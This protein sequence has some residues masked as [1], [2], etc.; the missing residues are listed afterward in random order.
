M[1]YL[2]VGDLA[3]SLRRV[4]EGGGK[5]IKAT[6]GTD[7]EYGYAAVQDPVG[8]CLALCRGREQAIDAKA[9]RWLWV[10]GLGRTSSA[11]G[12]AVGDLVRFPYVRSR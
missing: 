2:P 10:S 5:V 4:R 11:F 1:I 7:G 6:R 3:E 9:E 8:A 12:R